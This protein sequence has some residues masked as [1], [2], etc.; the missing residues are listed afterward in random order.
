MEAKTPLSRKVREFWPL[1]ILTAGLFLIVLAIQ[2]LGD[3]ILSQTLT[4]GLIRLVVVVGLFTFVGNSGKPLTASK[5]LPCRLRSSIPLPDQ[6]K[7][8]QYPSLSKSP[9]IPGPMAGTSL[10]RVNFPC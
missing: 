6:P 5:L 10:T 7:R 1:L 8:S 9:Q 2:L 3:R 4:E